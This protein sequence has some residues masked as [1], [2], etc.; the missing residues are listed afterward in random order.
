MG[1]PQ[2][3][4]TE[5]AVRDARAVF[6]RHGFDN[7]PL[8]ELERATGLGRSS[9]YHAFGSKRGLFDA[10]VTNYLDEVIRPSLTPLTGE[11]VAPDAF[12]RYLDMLK[13]AFGAQ[14]AASA[15]DGSD[16][17]LI[18]NA[19]T[20]PIGRDATMARVVDDYRAELRA[21]YLRGIRAARPQLEPRRQETLADACTGLVISASVLVRVSPDAAVTAVGTARDLLDAA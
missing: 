17:C 10:A 5:T 1:R 16:G 11:T 3:F 4:S 12:G 7:A 18:L 15:A 8:P 14:D 20:A 21:A 2:T 19:A 9:I 13:D 6:W